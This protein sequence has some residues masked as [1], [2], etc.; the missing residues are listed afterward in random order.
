MAK[1][2]HKMCTF[3]GWGR[4]GGGRGG[5]R[6]E[7]GGE[8]GGGR[9]EKGGRKGGGRREEGGR[10]GGGMGEEGEGRGEEGEREVRAEKG[11][12]GVGDI[13]PL[14]LGNVRAKSSETSF[15]HLKT[16]FTQIGR[17]YL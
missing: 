12:S 4:K 6:G 1:N 16:Y 11:V 2:I 9:G 10:K 17:C 8:E 14:S 15:P 3:L 7:E 5:G 13:A